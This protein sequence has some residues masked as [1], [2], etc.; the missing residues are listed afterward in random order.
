[1]S[2]SLVSFYHAAALA[3]LHDVTI[4]AHSSV[5]APLR[6]SKAPFRSIEVV[7]T[8][9]LDRIFNWGLR[10]I[11]K[12]NYD[13]QSLTAFRWPIAVV[14]EWRAWRQLRS[15]IRAGEFD[16]VLRVNPMSPALPSPFAFFLRMGPIPFVV[17]P[18]N[19]GLRSAPGFSQPDEKNFRLRSLYRFMPFARSTHRYAAAIICAASHMRKEFAKYS[20]KLFFIPENGIARSLCV[21][22]GRKPEPVAKLEL[23]FVGALIRRKACYLG[24][25]GAASLLRSNKAHFTIIG[26]GPERKNLEELARSLGV[27]ASVDF[28]GWLDHAE[29]LKRLRAADVVV[30]PAIREGG[31]GVVFEGLANGC[32]PVVLDY[33]GPGDIVHPEVGYKIPATNDDDVV[34]QIEKVLT[35]LAGDRELLLRLR[36]Q[37]MT[38][39]RECLTWEAKAKSSTQVLNWVVGRG[40]KPDLPPSRMARV[41]CVIEEENSG[42]G[43]VLSDVAASI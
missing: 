34:A 9:L 41:R 13:S 39:A 30:L 33:G 31:G 4:V 18:L 22:D 26:E 7:K 17:G 38:Y 5:E 16:V 37:G 29:V 10:R 8:P 20:D 6:R 1:V 24:V 36:R 42:D 12:Y 28:P 15:R 11:F 21:A 32:V 40:P 43:S 2:I 27:E 35:E 25:R 3:Q 19:G 14:F 23:I